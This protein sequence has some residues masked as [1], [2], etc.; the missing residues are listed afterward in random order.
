M[1]IEWTT[2]IEGGIPILG[3]LYATALGY[4]AFSRPQVEPNQHSHKIRPGDNFAGS[5]RWL[6][7]SDALSLG[8]IM[9]RRYILR[10]K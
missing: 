5:A 9:Y 6:C 7:C 3:G 8:T 10:Q 2:V 4:G 1:T